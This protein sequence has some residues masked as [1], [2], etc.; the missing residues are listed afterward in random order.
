MESKALRFDLMIAV[1]AL[2]ISA[3]A[4]AASVY[5]TH[6]ISQQN[7]L[8]SQQFGATTWPYLSFV[9]SYSPDFV[10]VDLRNNGVGPAII[11]TA[12]ITLDGRPVA[13]GKT[14]SSIDSVIE[15]AVHQADLD[16]S[17][18]RALGKV[19]GRVRLITTT[20]SLGA[21]DVLPAGS[22]RVLV[23]A[24][25]PFIT[26]RVVAM[27]GRVNIKLCYCSLVGRCWTKEL[28]EAKSI[29]RDAASCP[30]QLP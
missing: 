10:E 8:I 16:A 19:R 14:N 29:P 26:R 27:R 13:P 4:A 21:D 1:S 6:V 22:N 9:N 28:A 7:G 20:S 17:H 12:E 30:A 15:I 11:R 2:L 24:D 18:A 23:R 3:V 25:G 5:Q